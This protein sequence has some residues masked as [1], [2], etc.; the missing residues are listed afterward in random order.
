MRSDLLL[1][2]SVGAFGGLAVICIALLFIPRTPDLG[3]ALYRLQER[4]NPVVVGS[5][6]WRD[7]IGG[8]LLRAGVTSRGG[9]P[10]ADLELLE[11]TTTWLYGEKAIAA[12]VGVALPSLIFGLSALLGVPLGGIITPVVLGLALGVLGWLWPS[13]RVR[14]KAA[15]ERARIGR[16]VSSYID[17]VVLSRLSGAD[18]ASA[19]SGA[20]D[21]AESPLFRRV[22]Q[23]LT[24]TRLMQGTPWQ[25][26]A[27]LAHGANLPDLDSLATIM[28]SSGTQS[29][30][31]AELLRARARELRNRQL[32]EEIE[33][34]GKKAQAQT[35]LT[36]GLV[37]VLVLFFLVPQAMQLLAQ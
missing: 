9:V 36:V 12:M 1:M 24:R 2:L 34:A 4:P 16:T 27:T 10:H 17:L 37:M 35:M 18:T 3:D 5:T 25:A 14:G 20:A 23:E 29:T 33:L 30:P 19:I 13:V 26:L 15:T 31:V 8:R 11:M 6:S 22:R 21:I 28:A 7:R 32:A